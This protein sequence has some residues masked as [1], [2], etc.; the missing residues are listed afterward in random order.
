MG[1]KF[2]FVGPGQGVPGLPHEISEEEAENLGV[3]ELLADAL[4]AGTFEEIRKPAAKK[5][6]QEE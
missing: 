3:V 6:A 1:K 4:D 5:K 2:R